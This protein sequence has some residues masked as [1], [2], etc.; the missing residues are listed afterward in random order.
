[1]EGS[2]VSLKSHHL[3]DVRHRKGREKRAYETAPDPASLNTFMPRIWAFFETP[4][5][6]PAAIPA[7]W[8]P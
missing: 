3:I 4:H 2:R 6:V 7:T 8:V 5:L 1:M